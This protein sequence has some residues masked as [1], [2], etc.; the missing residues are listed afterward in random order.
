LATCNFNIVVAQSTT[1]N[2][3]DLESTMSATPSVFKQWTTINTIVYLK[4]I[5]NRAFTNVA[6]N[7]PAP[8]GTTGH[9]AKN[10]A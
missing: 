5:G 8:Q 2:S 7:V 6:I 4:I 10:I 1:N 9:H 3:A